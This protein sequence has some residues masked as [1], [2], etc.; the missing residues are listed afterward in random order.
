VSVSGS[1]VVQFLTPPYLQN[2]RTN[3]VTLMWELDGQANAEVHYGPDAGYGQVATAQHASSATGTEIY[4][5][6]LTN[7]APGSTY[8]YQVRTGTNQGPTGHFTTA[9]IGNP[10]FS[11][12]VWAD[13]QGANHGTYLEDPLEPT[14]SMFRHMA[15]SGISLAVTSGDLA[16]SGASYSDTRQ[17][18]LDRVAALLGTKV[19]WFVAWGN[20]DGGPTTVIRQFASWLDTPEVLITDWPHMTVGGYS[21]IP[22]IIRP[23]PDAGGGLINEYVRVDVRGDTFKASMIGFSPDGSVAGVLDQFTKTSPLITD[24]SVS[25]GGIRIEWTASAGQI[26]VQ[27]CEFIGGTWEDVDAPIDAAQGF[28]VVPAVGSLGFFRLEISR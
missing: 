1:A 23:R 17:F 10:D 15:S 13:S 27:R 22:G 5:C 24:V 8:Q 7:L 6:P 9:P 28:A 12:A 20:H 25:S 4:R 18:Y 14:K 3:A 19:P 2:L 21:D 16:E 26:Q 11:F